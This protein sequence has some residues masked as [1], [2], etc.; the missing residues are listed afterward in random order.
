MSKARGEGATPVL[1]EDLFLTE[2]FLIKGRLANK[3]RRLT[4]MLNDTEG[5]FLAVE[6]ATM[7][8]LKGEELI[9]TPSVL[10]NP[11]EIILAHELLELSGDAAWRQLGE[12]NKT[13]SVRAFYNGAIQLEL[14][15]SIEPGAYEPSHNGGQQYFIMQKPIVRGLNL[16]GRE[17]L[18]V[19]DG[20]DYAIIHKDRLAYVYDFT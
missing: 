13:V 7:I 1:V 2:S 3:Y 15:G 12:S 10:I 18:R 16:E 9:H 11:R 19:L 5:S 8:S 6:E 4:T 17:E 20:L 14:A